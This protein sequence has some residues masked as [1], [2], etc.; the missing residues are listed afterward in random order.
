ME[1]R[2][3][4]YPSN[5]PLFLFQAAKLT[6]RNHRTF[7]QQTAKRLTEFRTIKLAVAEI[8]QGRM[9]W[10]YFDYVGDG[11]VVDAKLLTWEDINKQVEVMES[12]AEDRDE[13]QSNEDDDIHTGGTELHLAVNEEKN[14]QRYFKVLG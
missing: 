5:C 4:A 10:E 8:Y 7:D 9:V 1:R 14:N 13:E 12:Q 2:C 6:Q 3:T 11:D